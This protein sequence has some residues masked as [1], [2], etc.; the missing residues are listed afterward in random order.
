MWFYWISRDDPGDPP[1]VSDEETVRRYR[2]GFYS[3]YHKLVDLP[4]LLILSNSRENFLLFFWK[5]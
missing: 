1:V 2:S 4:D 3:E 5:T